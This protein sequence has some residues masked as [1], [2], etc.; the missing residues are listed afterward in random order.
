MSS[1][2]Q[3][4][5]PDLEPSTPGEPAVY[6]IQLRGVDSRG[7]AGPWSEGLEFVAP[8]ITVDKSNDYEPGQDGWIIDHDGPAE[9]N[10]VVIR[11]DLSSVNY[12]PGTLGWSLSRLGDFELNTGEFRGQIVG[13]SIQIGGANAFHVDTIGNIWTGAPT[14]N[15]AEFT[16]RVSAQGALTAANATITG[17]SF[18]VGAGTSRFRVDSSGNMWLGAD[19]LATAPFRVTNTGALTSSN[20][21]ITGG[22]FTVGSGN[23]VFRVD[24]N[25]RMWLG[26]SN[27]NSAPF[28]VTSDG[29]LTATSGT[30]SGQLSSATGTLNGV[31]GSFSGTTSGTVSGAAINNSAITNGSGNSALR[32]DS[33]GNMWLG[34]TSFN[35][36]PF[37][38]DRNGNLTATSG[39]F[40]G[41]LS[42]AGGTF[43]GNLSSTVTTASIVNASGS[44]QVDGTASALL[45]AT[46]A[47][48]SSG[49]VG[50]GGTATSPTARF[51]IADSGARIS[52]SP[53]TLFAGNQQIRLQTIGDLSTTANVFWSSATNRLWRATSRR[54]TKREIEPAESLPSLLDLNPVTYYPIMPERNNEEPD[55]EIEAACSIK[56]YGVIAEDADDLGLWQ[57]VVYDKDGN[58]DGFS[59]DR[60]GVALIPY[61]KE[62][63]DRIEQLEEQLNGN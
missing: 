3:V 57:L 44:F 29:Q 28:R 43:S 30:F 62:L 56:H 18:S 45:S 26:N 48:I 24:S 47:W 5:I 61:V 27:F 16:F 33:V 63:Y 52:G 39:T 53:V 17:G 8:E 35:S 55:E 38:V 4:Q 42:G 22:N 10:N 19:S 21:T 31:T 41:N 15:N 50:I 51:D 34:N 1:R 46:R 40:S 11:G 7:N 12:I 25:G 2:E 13:G 20:A 59:Y 60:V 6:I 32:V 58:V 54:E 14:F 9:F 36:A 49:I 23:N 37:R